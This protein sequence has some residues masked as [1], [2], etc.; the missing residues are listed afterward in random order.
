M[1][2]ATK[3]A[4]VCRMEMCKKQQK[5]YLLY[6]PTTMDIIAKMIGVFA[7]LLQ[8]ALGLFAMA[9]SSVSSPYIQAN[10]LAYDH[11]TRNDVLFLTKIG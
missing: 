5:Y 8:S 11:L 9:V 2:K 1:I 4:K 3:K 10:Q 6:T 7:C